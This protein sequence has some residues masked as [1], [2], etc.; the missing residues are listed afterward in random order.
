M[1]ST[2]RLIDAPRCPYCAR[3]R[4]ALAEKGISFETVVI[5]LADRPA[6][7]YELNPIGKVPVLE[8]DGWVLPESAVINE[9]L[10]EAFPGPAL[11][12]ADPAERATARLLIFRHDDFTGPYY[13]LRRKEPGAEIAFAGELEAL[14]AILAATPY[15]TGSGFGLADIAYVPWVL[16]ARDLLAVSFEPY[17]SIVD[18][19]ARLAG[20]PSI[21]AE[22]EVIAAL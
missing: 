14:D 3:V 22:L 4:I 21:Q 18:W 2:L 17:P 16:R 13:A 19:L 15:L 6:W 9:Y 7:V 11:L 12:P 10:E 8:R 20:R 1:T 5:D